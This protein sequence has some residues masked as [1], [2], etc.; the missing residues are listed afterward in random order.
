MPVTAGG[1]WEAVNLSDCLCETLAGRP[2][3]D[4][5]RAVALLEEALARPVTDAD[6]YDVEARLADLRRPA[7]PDPG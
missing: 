3:L 6:E 5:E 1:R 4:H 7:D 2:A